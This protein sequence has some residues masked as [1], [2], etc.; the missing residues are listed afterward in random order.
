MKVIMFLTA[1]GLI[2]TLVVVD[3]SRVH[4]PQILILKGP[5]IIL[6][7]FVLFFMKN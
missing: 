3:V 2:I 6:F 1:S 7:K 4:V 5:Q